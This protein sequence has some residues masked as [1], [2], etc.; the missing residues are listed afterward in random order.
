S[1][2][3]GFEPPAAASARTSV[4]A[5]IRALRFVVPHC[6]SIAWRVDQQRYAQIGRAVRAR[7]KILARV[8]Q[9]TYEGCVAVS[10][11]MTLLSRS[12]EDSS[13]SRCGW[14][15]PSKY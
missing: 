6:V 4:Y 10:G 3:A 14:R 8:L 9:T 13:G 5:S 15:R 7:E 2:A 12:G 1:A 11:A